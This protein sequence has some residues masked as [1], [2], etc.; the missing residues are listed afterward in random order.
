M[1][2]GST[3]VVG[4]ILVW[5]AFEGRSAGWAV[6][7]VAA[8]LVAAGGVVKYLIPGRKLQ[9]SGVP[10]QTLLLGGI[11]G[12][13]GFFV[14]PVIGL[15]IGFVLGVYLAETQRLGSERAWPGTVE[16]LK[17]VGLGILIELAFTSVAALTWLVGLFV[18]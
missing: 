11:L 7:A 3:L 12:I 4:A 6:F 14:I 17:A 2:P 5:A 9:R 15:P 10:T 13:V 16:A 1:M 8:C 18:V